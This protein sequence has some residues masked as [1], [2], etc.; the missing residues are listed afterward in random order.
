MFEVDLNS[1]LKEEPDFTCRCWFI[2]FEPV[3]SESR[4]YLNLLKYT[5]M[6]LDLC[7]FV[8]I[9]EYARNITCLKKAEF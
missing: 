9:P 5:Q 8:N 1:D 7:N 4:I 6:C 3:I 2:L